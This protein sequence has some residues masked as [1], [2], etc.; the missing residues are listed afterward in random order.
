[1]TLPIIIAVAPNGARKTKDDHSAIPL[2]AEELAETA[3]SCMKAGASMIHLHV[4]DENQNHSLSVERYQDAI[5]QVSLKTEDE[6]FIQV[7]SESVET[8]SPAEQFKM[9]HSLKPSAVSIGIR[10]IRSEPEEEISQ[11]FQMMRENKVHPQ[12]IFY[13]A[14]DISMY[15]DWL[16][17][18]VLP[19][20]A[21]PVLFV[22]GKHQKEGI[23]EL[24]DL[25]QNLVNESS[26]KS[27]MTCGFGYQE[28]QVAKQTLK[29]GGHI[30][31]GFENN[32]L[33]ENRKVANNNAE[34]IIQIEK[35]IKNKK[36]II[37][38][39]S[40]AQEQMTPDW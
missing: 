36:F 30:R 22:I 8:Y 2:T 21:Y 20:R 28:F 34:L 39:V 7:T 33:L 14:Y 26:F 16:K 13:N 12:L 32:E 29:L 3:K 17:R 31:I 10:E 24:K 23:F 27:W 38:S 18:G 37:A 15:K 35:Y 5:K 6:I 9:I 25:N 4:R 11:H 19:G 40:E 1:M